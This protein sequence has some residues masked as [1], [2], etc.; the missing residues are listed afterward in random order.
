[1][2]HTTTV[3]AGTPVP[4]HDIATGTYTDTVTGIP[5]PGTTTAT[6]S[7]TPTVTTTNGTAVINDS[8]GITRTGLT[9]SVDSTSGASG[10]FDN[11]YTPGTHTTGPVSWTSDTQSGDGSVT[12]NKTV[13]LDQPRE[14]SGS[15]DD[16]ATVTGSNG[17]TAS[18]TGTVDITAS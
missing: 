4:L 2:T 9:F 3:P 12:F 1:L 14:T 18:A 17:F 13:Y 8:E 6:A 10:S 5:I 16:T 15:L 7:A 11:G